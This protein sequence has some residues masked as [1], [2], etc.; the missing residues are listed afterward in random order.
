[1]EQIMEYKTYQE[2]KQQLDQELNQ[3]AEGFVRI[4]YLLKIARDTDILK[5]SGYTTVAE[6]AKAEYGLDKTQVSRFI[7]INDKFSED[8]YSDRLQENYQGFGFSK[9]SLMLLL[10]DAINESITTEYSKADIQAIKDEVDA[11]NK[12]SD[13]E[14]M[15]EQAETPAMPGKEIDRVIRQ[16]AEDEPELYIEMHKALKD[17]N[18]TMEDIKENMVPDGDKTYSIRIPG[19]GRMMLMLN[20]EGNIT[21]VNVRSGKRDVY[22]WGADMSGA[23]LYLM[24][25]DVSP[26]ESWSKEFG[27]KCPVVPVQQ[28]SV[29]LADPLPKKKKPQPKKEA[30]VKKAV[31][32]W[33]SKY[34]AGDEVV[35]TTTTHGKRGIL[36]RKRDRKADWEVQV[37]GYIDIWAEAFFKKYDPEEEKKLEEA[38]NPPEEQ[39]P[40]QRSITEYPEYM[41]EA[42]MI[43]PEQTEVVDTATEEPVSAAGI[44]KT[45]TA[46]CMNEENMQVRTTDEPN[47]EMAAGQKEEEP[48]MTQRSILKQIDTLKRD[49]MSRSWQQAQIDIDMIK[50][51]VNRVLGMAESDDDESDDCYED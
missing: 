36:K 14:R 18:W 40:G 2:Y 4:G 44:P 37:G 3:T 13:I 16:L 46:T 31:P 7:H 9:L 22:E 51:S 30:K 5:E 27:R 20:T 6:F 24:D 33:E 23:W 41:P 32:E 45:E 25:F 1:M 42:E 49:V 10:P 21:L 48:D 29:S 15:I 11:E 43:P 47:D 8:G 38:M 34:S 28:K 19:M 17:P 26:E 12:V 50:D 35:S 39:V